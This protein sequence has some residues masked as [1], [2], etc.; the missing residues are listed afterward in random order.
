[1]NIATRFDPQG[2][3]NQGIKPKQYGLKPN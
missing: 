1:M 3:K 2:D